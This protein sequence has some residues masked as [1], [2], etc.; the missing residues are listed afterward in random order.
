[1]EAPKPIKLIELSPEGEFSISEQAMNTLKD[2]G[3]KHVAPIMIAGPLRKAIRHRFIN[4]KEGYSVEEKTKGIWMWSRPIE[5]PNNKGCALILNMEGLDSGKVEDKVKIIALS[6]LLSSVVV[7][8]SSASITEESWNEFEGIM[9]LQELVHIKDGAKD[10]I[11]EFPKYAPSF[12]WVLHDSSVDSKG[13]KDYFE[14]SL[15]PKSSP[16]DSVK[17]TFS[18]Y[19]TQRMCCPLPKS[20]KG[21]SKA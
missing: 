9:K 16:T 10:F 6:L 18:N 11:K 7:Y 5:L 21:T 3:N 15:K 19:F 4:Q 17:Q 2:L 20:S 13:A 8:N 14:D 1:M 12:Y